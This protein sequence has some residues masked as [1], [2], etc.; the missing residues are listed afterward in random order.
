MP[1]RLSIDLERMASRRRAL[2]LMG[3]GLGGAALAACNARAGASDGTCRPTPAEIRGPFPADGTNDRRGAINVFGKRGL[4]RSDIRSGFAG[5]GGVAEGV[6]MDCMIRVASASEGCAKLPGH[7]V[8]VWQCDAA[9]DYSLYNR[10]DTNY[11]RGLQACDAEG[12]ARFRS[13]VPGCYGGRYPHIHFEVFES[14]E[15]ATDGHAALLVSQLALPEAESRAA[16]RSYSGYGVSERNLSQLPMERDLAFADGAEGQVIRLS[17]DP[18]TGYRGE[19]T[20]I[21]S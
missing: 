11:L 12:I 15:S 13:I 10:E 21:L 2:G 9:G 18:E 17:G 3:V 20:V 14:V 16:Y 1:S 4:I 6:A 7:A 19:A 8:Y 5:I